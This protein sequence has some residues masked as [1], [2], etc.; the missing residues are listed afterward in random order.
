[1]SQDVDQGGKYTILWLYNPSW[2]QCM[3]LLALS[4]LA[5]WPPG[6]FSLGDL[7]S[8]SLFVYRLDHLTSC[9]FIL[10]NKF[11]VEGSSSTTEQK[12]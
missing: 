8:K 10:D 6:P 2:A 7:T 12:L 3:H 9:H 5:A 11:N 4:L 1:M